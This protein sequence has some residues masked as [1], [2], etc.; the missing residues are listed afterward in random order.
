MED[1]KFLKYHKID[2]I[3]ESAGKG[4]LKNGHY[5]NENVPFLMFNTWIAKEKIDGTNIRIMWDGKDIKVGGRTDNANLPKGLLDKINVLLDKT[6]FHSVFEDKV[7][8]LYG[9]GYGRDIQAVG[10][11]YSE[12]YNFILYDILIGK[13]WLEIQD[14]ED[15][16]KLLGLDVVSSFAAKLEDMLEFCKKGFDS[17]IGNAP[18][19]GLV[20][21]PF[22]GFKDRA[23]NRII[24]KMRCAELKKL[25][26]KDGTKQ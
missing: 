9:E 13:F 3:Y 6:K 5:K 25:E 24:V 18:A 10:S 11:L 15:I 2:N 4:K 19:E 21:T 22:G 17:K 20:A 8:Y 26:V 12:D 1:V 23:G 7:V 16:G 14:I